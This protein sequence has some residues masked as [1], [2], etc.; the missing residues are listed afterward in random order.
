MIEFKNLFKD[1]EIELSPACRKALSKCSFLNLRKGSYLLKED[2]ISKN[3]GFLMSGKIIHYYN[4]NGKQIIKSTSSKNTIVTGLTSF[5]NN[6]QSIENLLC[7][8]DAKIAMYTK[9]YFINTLLN[10]TEVQSIWR[11]TLEDNLIKSEYVLIKNAEKHYANS[12]KEQSEFLAPEK[13]TTSS[14]IDKTIQFFKT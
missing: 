10:F 2:A 12:Q 9:E 3:I 6:S 11:K 1:L 4:I 14:I 7:V 8:E 5:I 13:Y